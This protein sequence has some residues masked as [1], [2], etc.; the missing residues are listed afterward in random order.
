MSNTTA[1]RISALV[2]ALA[3]ILGAYGAHGL[4]KYLV[5][6]GAENA[7]KQLEWWRTGVAY[8]LPHAV[9][10]LILALHAP[11]RVWSWR[12]LLGGI[13]LFSGS[14]YAMALGGPRWLGAVT[15]FGGTLLI[16]GWLMLAF[17][18]V[19]ARGAPPSVR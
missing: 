14:L 18:P 12:F 10:M 16:A 3:V 6:F 4:D 11:L 13:V 9:V 19:G 5:Q 2:G 17:G 7:A 15:P 1:L 8:H